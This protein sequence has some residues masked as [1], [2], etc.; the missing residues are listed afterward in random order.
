MRQ[1]ELAF[2]ETAWANRTMADAPADV[3]LQVSV[4]GSMVALVAEGW[5]EVTL[6][7]IGER[8]AAGSL[9]LLT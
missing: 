5:R 8:T 7:A 9:T 4:D 3:P 2:T 6:A 1:R